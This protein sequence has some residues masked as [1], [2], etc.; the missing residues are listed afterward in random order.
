MYNSSQLI[1][2][3]ENYPPPSRYRGQSFAGDTQTHGGYTHYY[4]QSIARPTEPPPEIEFPAA[5]HHS[6]P[7]SFQNDGFQDTRA[8]APQRYPSQFESTHDH[9]DDDLF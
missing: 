9:F 7:Y 4:E 3:Q 6:D 5:H 8:V 1:G 2:Y